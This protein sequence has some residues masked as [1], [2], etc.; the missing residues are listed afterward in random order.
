MRSLDNNGFIMLR[1]GC[2]VKCMLSSVLLMLF[3]CCKVG[4]PFPPSNR[5]SFIVKL[6]TPVGLYSNAALDDAAFS[7]WRLYSAA[8]AACCSKCSWYGLGAGLV[9]VMVA[10]G[11]ERR[12]VGP[13][14]VAVAWAAYGV[15]EVGEGER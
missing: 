5:F 13:A 4:G 3:W 15:L 2:P 1:I 8:M 9:L 6:V 10:M 14:V 7:A 11:S 12:E